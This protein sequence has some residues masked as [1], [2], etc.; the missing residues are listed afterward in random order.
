MQSVNRRV[1]AAASDLNMLESMSCSTVSFE[2]LLGHCNEVLKKNQNDVS[3]LAD[4]LGYVPPRSSRSLQPFV[5]T[6]QS[7][8]NVLSDSIRP[9]IYP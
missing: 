5:F 7:I 2:E 3:A 4:S 9:S 8:V 1:S 6:F